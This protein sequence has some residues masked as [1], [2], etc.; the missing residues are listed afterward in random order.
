M[1]KQKSIKVNAVAPE[2]IRERI[3]FVFDICYN[4]YSNLNF[5]MKGKQS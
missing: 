2:E 3:D 4:K 1:D 5:C